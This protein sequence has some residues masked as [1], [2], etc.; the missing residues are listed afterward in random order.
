MGYGDT[1]ARGCAALRLAGLHSRQKGAD[2][3]R[4]GPSLNEITQKAHLPE[5][6]RVKAL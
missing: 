5:G 2:L 3:H 1:S 4:L 6:C